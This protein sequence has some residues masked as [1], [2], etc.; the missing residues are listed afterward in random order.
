MVNFNFLEEYATESQEIDVEQL[1]KGTNLKKK[2]YI[3]AIFY[4]EVIERK[5]QGKGIMKYKSGRVYEGDWSNDVRHGHGYERYQ[6][7][8][9]YTG[10][11]E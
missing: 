1:K 4:G 3:D 11:F 9:V 7:G 10:Q 2:R 8:N 5:R 6:N